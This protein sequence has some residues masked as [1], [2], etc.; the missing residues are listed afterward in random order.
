MGSGE[1]KAD[2]RAQWSRAAAGWE[3][4]WDTLEK[5]AGPVA[6]R[7][8]ELSGIGEGGRILD[9]ATGIGEPAITAA[10]R[11]GP[12][13]RVV[14][15]DISP[16]MLGIARR[17]AAG[18]GLSNIEFL[19]ADAEALDLPVNTFD[20]IISRWGLMFLSDLDGF[21]GRTRKLLVPGGRFATAFWGPPEKVPMLALAIGVI[22]NELALAPPQAG[23]EGPFRLSEAGFVTGA[24]TRG[25]FSGV[26]VER[27]EAAFEWQSAQDY[28]QFVE[29]VGGPIAALLAKVPEPRQA[30]V[31]RA[32]EE[33]AGAF[34][35]G[36]GSVRMTNEILCVAGRSGGE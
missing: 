13:G 22:R 8:V 9:L 16:D 6:G 4:W 23:D 2:Q 10:R 31:L 15:L 28:R 30:G 27:M 29:E 32:I 7:L 19:E 12:S 17:R 5:G 33:A 35:A 1:N 25:G 18:L 34:A 3:R 36:D 11:V 20:A 21:L 26:A 14:A 24:L